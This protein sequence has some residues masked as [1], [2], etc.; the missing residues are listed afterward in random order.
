MQS[1]LHD[2]K[3]DLLSPLTRP[4]RQTVAVGAHPNIAVIS[5]AGF[6]EPR[7][8]FRKALDPP[9]V[10]AAAKAISFIR[11]GLHMYKN[12]RIDISEGLLGRMCGFSPSW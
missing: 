7:R 3:R 9:S 10:L 5:R 6:A 4:Q 1:N 2:D 11:I 12:W 8:R